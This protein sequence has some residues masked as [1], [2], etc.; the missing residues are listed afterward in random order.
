MKGAV[1]VVI[2]LGLGIVSYGEGMRE[3]GGTGGDGWRVGW[4]FCTGAM[5][6]GAVRPGVMRRGTVS[7][8]FGKKEAGGRPK[9]EGKKGAKK[10]GGEV[11]GEELRE[12]G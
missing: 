9:A 5:R 12:M 4:G 6:A 1:G 8:I 3:E 2:I 7:M 10:V 11:G